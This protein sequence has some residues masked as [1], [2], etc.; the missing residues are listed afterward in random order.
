MTD[1]EMLELA[2]R[3]AG[4][5]KVWYLE[6]TDTPYIGPRYQLGLPL[7]Y[8]T[9][10]PLKDDGDEARLEAVLGLNVAWDSYS[11]RVGGVTELFI[12]HD[13]NKQAARRFAGVRAAAE[14]G[15]SMEGKA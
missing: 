10:R 4:Y 11:V 6:D 7:A 14:I 2:A 5:G 9:F 12:H 15:K 1:R 3:A 13:G 8:K